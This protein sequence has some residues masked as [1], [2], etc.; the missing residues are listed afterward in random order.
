MGESNAA[1]I[2]TAYEDFARGFFRRTMELSGGAFTIDVHNV[3]ADG[4]VV[5]AL[6]TVNARRN[7]VA[8]SFPEVH[9]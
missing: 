4:D 3:L 5:V 6:T 1:I 2:R 8:A 9:V 7:G